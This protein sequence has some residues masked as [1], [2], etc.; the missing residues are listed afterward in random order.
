MMF[1]KEDMDLL[2]YNTMEGDQIEPKQMVGILPMLLI[3]GARAL[4]TGFTQNIPPHDP[5]DIIAAVKAKIDGKDPFSVFPY[6]KG[7]R[8]NL[9]F[10]KGRRHREE[11]TSG[12]PFKTSLGMTTIP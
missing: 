2:D 7:F 6:Y 9:E 11:N 5:R 1:P 3:N 4:S 10:D 8:G 12:R